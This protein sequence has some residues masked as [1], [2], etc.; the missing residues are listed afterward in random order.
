M[1]QTPL[2][3]L[4]GRII[5]GGGGEDTIS[6][7][8]CYTRNSPSGIGLMEKIPVHKHSTVYLTAEILQII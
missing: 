4:L 2:S 3:Q 1:Y 5:V 6:P 7:S 8:L